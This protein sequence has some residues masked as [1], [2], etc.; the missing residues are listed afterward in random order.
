MPPNGAPEPSAELQRARNVQLSMLPEIPAI[1][2]LEIAAHYRPCDTLGGDFYDFITVDQ[3]RLGI[4]VADVSGHGAAAALL[5]AVAKK[6]LQLCG[7]GNPSPRQA[8]LEVNDSIRAD[9]P[10]G[11]FLSALY[12]VLDIRNHKLALAS[13]GH[14]PPLW[15]RGAKVSEIQ[16]KH[17]APVLGVM[18]S[19]QLRGYLQEETVQLAAD[20]MLVFYTDGITEAFN[21]D[22]AMYGETR[23]QSRVRE[24]A[25]T[26]QTLVDTIRHD[27]DKFRS[28]A[29]ISDDETLVVVR[30]G[31]RGK[32]A[33]PL[34]ASSS[35]PVA[36]MP[37]FLLP[38]L[39]RDADV[40]SVREMIESIEKPVL[41]ITGPAGAGKTRVAVAAA[42]ATR[43]RF[44]GGFHYVDLRGAVS[45]MDVCRAVADVMR[46][47]D[48]ETRLGLR[49]AMALQSPAGRSMLLLDNCEGCAAAAKRCIE[50]W[51][52]RARN[53]QV[54]AT[55]RVA[56]EAKNE[57]CHN[58]APMDSPK[59]ASLA[60]AEQAMLRYPIIRLFTQRAQQTDASFRLTDE[61]VRD[62]AMIC[63]KLDGL[64]Q[65][66]E[67]AAARVDVLTP[68]QI[69]EGLD[70]RLDLLAEGDGEGS[71]TLSGTLAFSWELL[72]E[73][74][75]RALMLLSQFP[76]GFQ[77]EVAADVLKGV[78]DRAP[79]DL[80]GGLLKHSLLYHDTPDDLGGDRRI[81]V[82]ESFRLFAL[83]KLAAD[84]SD[85]RESYETALLN[86]ALELWKRDQQVGSQTARERMQFELEALLEIASQ[87]SVPENRAWATVL[88]A[89][90][91]HAKGEKTRAMDMLRAAQDGISPG[92]DED[93]WIRLTD[94]SLRAME[95]PEA[96]IAML[97]SI[98]GSDDAD[99]RFNALYTRATALHAMGRTEEAV[100][101]VRQASKIAGLSRSRQA[102]L[103]SRLGVLFADS[104]RTQEARNLFESA[105]MLARG[106]DD[107]LLTGRTLF[108]L[109]WLNLRSDQSPLSVPQLTETLEIAEYEGDRTLEASALG[110]LA[111]ALHYKGEKQEAE[112]YA[113]RGIRICRELGRSL[114]EC[115]QL[116]A[117]ARIYHE[118][119][120]SKEALQMA[121]RGRDL[122][123]EIGARRSE[124]LAESNLASL[125]L[126]M[127]EEDG[128]LEAWQTSYHILTELN[129][130]RGALS[131][132]GNIGGLH[133]RQWRNGRTPRQLAMA[134]DTL[135]TAVNERRQM[136]YDPLIEQEIVLAELLI[137]AN[138]HAD[139][140]ELLEK[141]RAAAG[142]RGDE[143]GRGIAEKS[144]Q[145]LQA[146]AAQPG[147]HTRRVT[148]STQ[149]MRAS[150]VRT[151]SPKVIAPPPVL[152]PPPVV[153][154]PPTRRSS[155]K[156]PTVV[157]AP[158]TRRSSDKLPTVASQPKKDSSG[159]ILIPPKKST[160][161]NLPPVKAKRP[162]GPPG[163]TPKKRPRGFQ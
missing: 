52:T 87:T 152:T 38:L 49:I 24:G 28:K 148:P 128:A 32:Q 74:E 60:S 102:M 126:E 131:C 159:E 1:E 90:I 112:A 51:R 46:L 83:D 150:G 29:E 31:K 160:S 58:V 36:E 110:G 6:V 153:R 7:R 81:H 107:K 41:T 99:I 82:Y 162:K 19:E 5:M 8:L 93:I 63:A 10:A 89:P 154:T 96:V 114:N 30:V 84:E 142:Q 65:A 97:E 117:L 17:N 64:P 23:L 95:A 85:A 57:A 127:G 151:P 88:A 50:E 101:V 122:A 34:I 103:K 130:R 59:S 69:A 75:Q 80:L 125:R 136:G 116:S 40:T 15:R 78:G 98:D 20:D 158:S 111:L 100:E 108:N 12:G 140:G 144:G 143:L 137:E 119:G 70:R 21:A 138:R 16:G 79:E 55:S 113:L 53:L 72:T 44:P 47:G 22:R 14:N 4:V 149:R 121:I 35:A 141:T 129:D 109:G 67:L 115:A 48:D 11:M 39:G 147:R 157:Q 25:L 104:G 86:Y 33:R 27:V 71:N 42:E 133:A 76:A 132:L 37:Q 18:P 139:A 145:M 163:Q 9:M 161:A 62:V 120:R 134:I 43:D 123:R 66:V 77:P 54:L 61:N 26:A 73:A 68:R 135:S 92:S 146:L 118:Q 91:L 105:L 156:L 13:C 155:D 3:W 56:T 106:A 45:P 2:S 124:A 94:G